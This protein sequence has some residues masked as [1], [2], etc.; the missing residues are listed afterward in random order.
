[1]LLA[2]AWLQISEDSITGSQQRDK[3]FWR[4][5][6]AYYEKSN[7]S[8]VARTQANLKTHWHYMNP[9]AVT[10]NQM[11][12]VLKSQHLSGWSE[13]DLKRATFEHY[14][15]RYGA[16]FRHEHIWNIVKNEQKWKGMQQKKQQKGKL[17]IPL[18]HLVIGLMKYLKNI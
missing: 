17:P 12:I 9:F 14:H 7:M 13:D 15:A 2:K 16:D 6:I 1:M 4:R 8:N 10:F 18:R 11:Y 3:E 5:I